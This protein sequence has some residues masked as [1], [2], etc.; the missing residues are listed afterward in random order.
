LGTTICGDTS[1]GSATCPLVQ[2][3]SLAASRCSTRGRSFGPGAVARSTPQKLAELSW[4]IGLLG[5]GIGA[6]A[7]YWFALALGIVIALSAVASGVPFIYF[8]R[9]LQRLLLRLDAA[10]N[11]SERGSAFA[12]LGAREG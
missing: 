2:G 7:A 10:R 3:S 12:L 4:L 11:A 9:R 6:F 1:S 5:I 8:A